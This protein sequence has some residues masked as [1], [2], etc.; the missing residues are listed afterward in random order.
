[1]D[2]YIEPESN[3]P[4][5]LLI[6]G[7]IDR[8]AEYDVELG[9]S[10][11]KDGT[12]DVLGFIIGNPA[13]GEK[14][15][16]YLFGMDGLLSRELQRK[17]LIAAVEAVSAVWGK[18]GGLPFGN[19]HV[20]YILR[21]NAEDPQPALVEINATRPI[22]GNGVR[23]AREWHGELNLVRN[24]LRAALGLPQKAPET[25]PQDSLLLLG[26]TPAVTGTL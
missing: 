9:I 6:E 17:L 16:G 11:L 20:E 22:G 3:G 24:G 25:Q 15:K 7:K 5:K 18:F 19:F 23:V 8:V 10:R 26:I 14:E 2:I 13:P 21:G 12:L 1:R 4:P